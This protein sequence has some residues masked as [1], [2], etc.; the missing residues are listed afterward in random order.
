VNSRG[1]SS[2]EGALQNAYGAS[3]EDA[4]ANTA[5]PGWRPF[6]HATLLAVLLLMIAL[7][8]SSRESIWGRY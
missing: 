6:R 4:A 3:R 1:T 5:Y 2:D 7:D 8:A